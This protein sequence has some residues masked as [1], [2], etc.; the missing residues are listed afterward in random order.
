MS[1]IKDKEVII[2]IRI[3]IKDETTHDSLEEIWP[4][5]AEEVTQLWWWQAGVV[6]YNR[7]TVTPPLLHCTVNKQYSSAVIAI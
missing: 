5:A 4:R 1:A 2:V 3:V 6:E 7:S